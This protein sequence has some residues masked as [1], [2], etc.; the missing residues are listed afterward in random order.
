MKKQRMYIKFWLAIRHTTTHRCTC[1]WPNA[2]LATTTS[3]MLSRLSTQVSERGGGGKKFYLFKYIY[4]YIVSCVVIRMDPDH[5]EACLALSEVYK[6]I[7]KPELALEVITSH[8]SH[9]KY[10]YFQTELNSYSDLHSTTNRT[11][12]QTT[13]ATFTTSY[14]WRVTI[15]A[16]RPHAVISSYPRASHATCDHEGHHSE[17][18]FALRTTPIR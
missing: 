12:R 1:G 7:G 11:T 6:R 16:R 13:T 10:C 8:T 17:S 4:I 18:Q 14:Q 5:A 15:P 9:R 3:P 2:I